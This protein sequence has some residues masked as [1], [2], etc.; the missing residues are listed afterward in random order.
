[1]AG[2][3][4]LRDRL[5]RLR[6]TLDGRLAV[7]SMEDSSILEDLL[8]NNNGGPPG[9]TRALGV[10]RFCSLERLLCSNGKFDALAEDNNEYCE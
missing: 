5:Q 9:K 4:D 2:G 3:L 7:Q 10:W 6:L 1:M 8:P